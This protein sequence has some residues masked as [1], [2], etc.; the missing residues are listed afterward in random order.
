MLRFLVLVMVGCAVVCSLD[1]PATAQVT[2]STLRGTVKAADDGVPMA[3]AAV[4]LIHIPSGGQ[5]TTS[6]NADGVFVFTNMRVGG[7]YF[8]KAEA[9]GFKVVQADNIFL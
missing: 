1:T 8:L 3:E 2:T 5:F 6:T 7:P 4:T 9:L